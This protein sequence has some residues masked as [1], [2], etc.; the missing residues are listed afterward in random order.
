MER[1]LR[2]TNETVS[3]QIRTLRKN[4]GG[5]F[6]VLSRLTACLFGPALLWTSRREQKQLAGG[7]TY[8]PKNHHR[9]P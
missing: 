3:Q 4:I 6:G 1:Q 8:V 9:A 7:K 5:E 2:R